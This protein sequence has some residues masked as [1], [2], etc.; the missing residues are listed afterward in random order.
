[1]AIKQV[2]RPERVRRAPA[3]FSWVDHR[4]VRD[5]YIERCD[6]H[7]AMLYLFLVTVA[8]SCGLSWYSDESTAR[9]LSMDTQRLHR[10]RGDLMRAGL[11]AWARPVYQVL[12]LDVPVIAA[13]VP[14]PPSPHEMTDQI[15]TD[16][17]RAKI[18]GLR[19]VLGKRP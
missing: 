13:P 19:A 11:I 2:L 6:A 16:D 14:M 12:A 1:M 15:S 18:A 8:D 17:I 5:R 4:L 7:A 9:R 10:A 3:H